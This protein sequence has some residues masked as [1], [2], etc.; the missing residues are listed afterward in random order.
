MRG[1]HDVA[2]AQLVGAYQR[3][4]IS[5]FFTPTTLQRLDDIDLKYAPGTTMDLGDLYAWMQRSVYS[6]IAAGH[7]IPLIRRNLQRDY[8]ATLSRIANRPTPGTPADAQ[9][10]A[11]YQLGA[12]HDTI[13]SALRGGVPDLMTRAHLQAMLSDVERAQDAHYVI[14][15]Q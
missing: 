5:R 14:P 9:S 11:A 2:F 8:A 13:A 4:V 15:V 6:D 10:L 1:R 7:S 3:S 12:L